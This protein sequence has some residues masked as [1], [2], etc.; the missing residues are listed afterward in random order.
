MD[1]SNNYLGQTDVI[2]DWLS[3][4]K[5]QYGFQF[6]DFLT[7]KKD[8]VQEDHGFPKKKTLIVCHIAFIFEEVLQ[9]FIEK[10]LGFLA[11]QTN[12]FPRVSN[13]FQ[14]LLLW[15]FLLKFLFSILNKKITW[16]CYLILRR[17]KG[18]DN[19]DEICR[20]MR[21]SKY[22]LE[23]KRYIHFFLFFEK[24]GAH[25]KN[26]WSLDALWMPLCILLPLRTLLDARKCPKFD[27]NCF[28]ANWLNTWLTD[29][30]A[31]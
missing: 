31:N 18:P 22:F 20:I 30:L 17:F 15:F 10:R 3:K 19:F 28:F 29:P 26:G 12:I 24:E 11:Q 8:V 7:D 5:S 4:Q 13:N 14:F 6:V 16:F 9:F 27:G 2:T 25:T 1:E 23:N 21:Q